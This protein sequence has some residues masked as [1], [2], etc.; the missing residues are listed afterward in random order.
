MG[1]AQP[2][3]NN[4][5]SLL[6]VVNNVANG[7][8]LLTSTDTGTGG[9]TISGIISG[10]GGLTKSGTSTLTLSGVNTFTGTTN[11]SAGIVR[12]TTSTA[13]LGAGALTLSGGTLQLANDTGLNYELAAGGSKEM[14]KGNLVVLLLAERARWE[15]A[16]IGRAHV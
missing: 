16:Q 2:R 3:T 6:S 15:C 10:T 7:G 11:V 1:A 9:T 5:T 12:A 14:R 13:A 4:S 8:F